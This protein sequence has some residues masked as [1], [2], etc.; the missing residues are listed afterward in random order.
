MKTSEALLYARTLRHL[1][2]VQFLGRARRALPSGSVDRSPAPPLRS[3]SPLPAA[4][5]RAPVLTGPTSVAM[6][7]ERGSIDSASDWTD[8]ARTALW[9]Y[10]LHYFDDLRSSGAFDRVGW[11]D[12]LIARWIDENGHGSAPAW[13]AYPTSLRIVNWVRWSRIH[14]LSSAA[15]QSLAEQARHLRANLEWHLLGNHLFAN[16]KALVFAGSAFE[17]REAEEWLGKGLSLLRRELREQVLADGGHFERSPM[18]H[19]LVLEDVLDL[20]AL[21]RSTPGAFARPE[22]TEEWLGQIA[23][24]MGDWLARMSHPDGDISLFNDAAMGQAPGPAALRDYALRLGRRRPAAPADGVTHL[25][26]SGYVRI[27][28]GAAVALLD[29]GEIGPDHLPGHAHADTL[30]FELSLDGRRLVVDSGTSRYEPGPERLAQRSTAAH[31]TIEVDGESS[32]E[33]W[34]SFRV[35]RRARPLGLTIEEQPGRISV[36]CG[37]DGYRRLRGRVDHVRTWTLHE[38][39]LELGDLLTGSFDAAVARLHLHPEVDARSHAGGVRLVAPGMRAAL[40]QAD[41]ASLVPTPGTWHPAF[42][43]AL[44]NEHLSCALPPGASALSTRI[45]W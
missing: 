9:R 33:V 22:E 6:L 14:G 44:P 15:V 27:G 4:A 39:G 31:N 7:G 1:K 19:A 8:P 11:N 12:A 28:A 42:G 20:V 16:A 21:V 36:R 25:A 35:A 5:D 29:V 24:R 45:T 23:D 37:H 10:H 26:E 38:N 17:G 41:G 34:S 32:S 30:S 40:A 3:A 18:Y 2:P 13:D 43:C